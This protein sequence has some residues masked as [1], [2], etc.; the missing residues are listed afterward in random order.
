MYNHTWYDL[1]DHFCAREKSLM[2]GGDN[3]HFERLAARR[4]NYALKSNPGSV[5][6][7]FLRSAAEN[8]TNKTLLRNGRFISEKIYSH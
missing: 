4:Y 8:P 1:A 2:D 5:R 3:Q 6:L 7:V